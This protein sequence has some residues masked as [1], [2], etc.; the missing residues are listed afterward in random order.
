V[1]LN[2]GVGQ[3]CELEGDFVAEGFEF[4]DVVALLTFWIDAWFV[5]AGAQ[6]V[7]TGFWIAS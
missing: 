2:A 1:R 6:V 3:A 7:I 4:A 5:V